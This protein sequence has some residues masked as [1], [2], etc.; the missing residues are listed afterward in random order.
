MD[1]AGLWPQVA[2]GLRFLARYQRAD[3]KMPHEISQAAAVIPWFTDYPYPYY[4]ADTTPYWI[5]AV[6]RYWRA[7]GDEALLDDLW[8]DIVE[9]YRWCL[10]A[11]TDGDGIIENTVGGLG[12]VEVGAIGAEIHQD[13]YLAG[14]WM[15]ALRAVRE[16]AG[17]RAEGAM[18][19]EA[20]EL[21]EMATRTLEDRYWRPD[22]GHYAFG[23]LR[24]GETND[25]LTVWPATAGAFGL[26]DEERGRRN[27][28][29]MAGDAISSDW[30]A[31]MLDAGHELFD[32][33]GYN[34]GAVWPFV[35]GFVSWGQYRYR[36]PWSGFPLVDAVAQT[37]FDW[38]RGRHPELLSGVFYRPLD[39]AVPQQFFATSMLVSPLLAGT[40]GWEPDAPR[41]R[42]RLAPQPPPAWDRLEARGLGVGDTRLDVTLT[43]A[44]GRLELTVDRRGPPITLDIDLSAPAGARS[45]RLTVGA[46]A[47]DAADPI[48]TE[49]EVRIA[50]PLDLTAERTRAV[51]TWEGG[52]AID[53]PTVDLAPGRRSRGVRVLDL[54]ADGDGWILE[55]EGETGRGYEIRLRGEPVTVDARIPGVERIAD[56]GEVQRFRVRFEAG[57]AAR[58]TRRI[59]FRRG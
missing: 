2:D 52:L 4:H 49:R 44:S 38:A 43:R 46:G 22:R 51:L 11:E 23:I 13:I 34:M 17:A 35:S 28:R 3:G 7:S 25:A 20:A 36:R 53:P 39:T 55:L 47:G 14:V 37:T 58:D 27:M 1:L 5:V 50:A 57:E 41:G 54:V 10:T 29:A 45:V 40:L 6:W 18:A 19:A 31:R 16:M 42:A 48:A 30:G 59:R 33:M 56:D 15:E 12:A 9:A 32:P 8:P 24:S 26:F 21:L